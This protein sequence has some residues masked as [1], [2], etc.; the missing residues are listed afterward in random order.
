MTLERTLTE[1]E[2]LVEYG[3]GY[4]LSRNIKNIHPLDILPQ[5]HQS[6]ILTYTIG[7][8]SFD[9]ILDEMN[10]I[11]DEEINGWIRCNRNIGEIGFDDEDIKDYVA[12]NWDVDD[13]FDD[14]DIKDYITDNFD[15]EDV[16]GNE[17]LED[18]VDYLVGDMSLSEILDSKD[19]SDEDVL[20][21]LPNS[22]ITDYVAERFDV[23]DVYGDDDIVDRAHNMVDGLSLNE[24]LDMKGMGDTDIL[25]TI[26]T[27]T[28][29]DYV[30]D[31]FALA[32]WV[33][34]KDECTS[35]N[36]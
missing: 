21:C 33:Q 24:F 36:G 28:L 12:E 18:R 2:T 35:V 16:Y 23:D 19:M 17:Y 31:N 11:D 34:W 15:I 1:L 29:Y 6:D 7:S 5:M 8:F 3:C 13:V 14:Y 4:L 10:T 27:K 22:S 26:D 9:E 20:D 25:N 32:D 30:T